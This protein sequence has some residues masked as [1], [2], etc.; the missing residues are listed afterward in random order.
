MKLFNINKKIIYFGSNAK[1]NTDLVK[2]FKESNPEGLWFHL[3]DVPSSHGFYLSN[4]LTNDELRIIGNILLKLSKQEG[5]H[6]MDICKINDVSPTKTNGLVL[7]KNNKSVR[8]KVI[9]CFKLD[10][11]K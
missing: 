8:I 3:C 1:E 5:K 10:D 2:R 4:D 7:I 11:Y 6:N 9:N